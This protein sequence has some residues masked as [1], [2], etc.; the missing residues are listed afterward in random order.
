MGRLTR[1]KKIEKLLR[2]SQD[3]LN[4][5]FSLFDICTIC[6]QVVANIERAISLMKEER[7]DHG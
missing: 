1:E 4:R 2:D 5:N 7:R 6:E 3:L